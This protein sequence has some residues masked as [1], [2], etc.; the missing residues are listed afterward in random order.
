MSTMNDID[1]CNAG[2]PTSFS[3]TLLPETSVDDDDDTP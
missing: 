2:G 1:P 3:G